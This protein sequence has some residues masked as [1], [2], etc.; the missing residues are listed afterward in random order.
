MLKTC[1]TIVGVLLLIAIFTG[2]ESAEDEGQ[3]MELNDKQVED[4]VRRSYQYVAMYNVNNKF[5][6]KQGGW[7]TVD[8]DT[9][10]KDHTMREIARP[11][12]DTLYVSA[13]IDLRKDPVILEMPAFD[14]DYVSLMVTGYDHYVNVPMA[15]RLGDFKKPEKILFYAE[16][17]EGYDG[18]PVDG[19]DRLFE[20]TGDFISAVLRI[21]PHAKDQERFQRIVKQMEQVKVTTLSEFK[22]GEPKPIDDIEFPTVGKRDADIFENNLLEVMQFVFNHTTI[23]P[24]DELDQEL[25]AAYEPLGV[26]P[27][28]PFDPDKVAK[29]DGAKFRKVSEQVFAE[30]MAKTTDEEFSK[31]ELFGKFKPKGQ[32]PLDLLVFQSVLGPIG[33][34]A[35]EAVYPAVA[36]SGGKPLNAMHDYVIRMSADQLPPTDVFWSLTLYDQQNGFFIPNDQKKYSVGENAGMQLNED[37]GIEVYVA[38][39]KPEGVPEENWLPIN[40][41]DED[42]DI[43]LRVYVADLEK[44]KTWAAPKAE[45]L[46]TGGK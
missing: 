22:G 18:E 23:D 4:L 6:M 40:R 25:L 29:I 3:A 21:M 37:G 30:E 28:K 20:C 1:K 10:L 46:E 38:A 15:T 27:G 2:A 32:M 36:A 31:K 19:V 45:K 39:E 11:N 7:N 43:V 14:S 16:R 26:V 33:L 35:T 17:T 9:K 41:K 42:M 5:A 44:M 8:A 34:P 24:Q 13:L 12:N